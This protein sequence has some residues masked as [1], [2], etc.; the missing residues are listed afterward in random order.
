MN[1]HCIFGQDHK[2]H[3]IHCNE[4]ECTGIIVIASLMDRYILD[5][6]RGCA[7]R[8]RH[9]HSNRTGKSLIVNQE[10]QLWERCIHSDRIWRAVTR[11]A[12]PQ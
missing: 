9:I 8:K 7:A 5:S 4:R 6:G 3:Q 12:Y 1:D 2:D 11:E 10:V